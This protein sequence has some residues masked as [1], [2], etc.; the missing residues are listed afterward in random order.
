MPESE[1]ET[2][3]TTLK[4]PEEKPAAAR[5]KLDPDKE[6]PG[7]IGVS[8]L[9][10]ER[11]LRRNLSRYLIV[12]ICSL[13]L[14][15]FFLGYI[16]DLNKIFASPSYVTLV[17]TITFVASVAIFTLTSGYKLERF[18]ITLRNWKPAL[19]ESILFTIPVLILM[20]LLKWAVIQF[21]PGYQHEILF[22]FHASLQP[23]LRG[24]P[25]GHLVW[26]TTMVLYALIGAPLQELVSRGGVQS[27]LALFLVGKHRNLIAI[28]LTTLV[29]STTHMAFPFHVV[30]LSFFAGLFWGWLFYRQKT[31]IGVSVSHAMIGVWFFW[32]LGVF[33]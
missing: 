1:E 19:I 14:Y 5:P 7:A 12:M 17:L 26:F 3:V 6:F 28:L 31:L 9:E 11:S 24:T 4:R 23:A 8:Q 18:G 21:I 20:T 30:M 15:T 27:G 32:L 10:K 33:T 16:E 25:E 13:C 2:N 22:N 29:F